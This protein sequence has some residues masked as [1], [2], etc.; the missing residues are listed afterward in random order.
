M[1]LQL[2]ERKKIV[3]HWKKIKHEFL[4][5]FLFWQIINYNIN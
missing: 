2:E 3:H 5:L 1:S 4:F